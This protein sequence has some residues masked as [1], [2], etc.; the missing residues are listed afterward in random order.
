[1]D[2]LP[3][4]AIKYLDAKSGSKFGAQSDIK[5]MRGLQSKLRQ[6]ARNAR[7]GD[8]ANLNKARIADV[9]ADAITDDIS[10]TEGGE[11]VA[12]LVESAV[13][14]SRELND[15]FRKGAVGTLL[16]FAK[17]GEARV[18][19][20]L[21][22]ENSIGV[23][24]PK[25][26]EAFDDIIKAT[27][28][29]QVKAA[30]DDFIKNKFFDYAVEDG[31]I[32]RSRAESFIRSNKEVLGRLTGVSED[33]TR[34]MTS[35]DVKDLRMAQKGR[36]SFDKPAISRATMFIEK[37]PNKAFNDV[38]GSRNPRREMSNLVNMANRDV[39]GE[40]LDGL[41][42][43]FSDYVKENAMKS[44]FISGGKLD[45][46]LSDPKTRA[47]MKKL[48][49][50]P[51]M[52]RWDVIQHTAKRLDMQRGARASGEG[53]LADEPGKAVSMLAG[54]MG[55]M[56]GHRMNRV[57]G[58]GGN[59]QIPGMAA[60]RARDLLKK[61]LDPAKDLLMA[62]VQDDKLFREVLL[63]KVEP[64]GTLPKEA[65]RR[66]NAWMATLYPEDDE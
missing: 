11:E 5:E 1:M 15:K 55:A 58:A 40:A 42:A 57:L 19:A 12:G 49:S 64:D 36:V 46:Y 59:I 50:A 37:G 48:Y 63:A 23:A 32:N 18:P 33:L 65:T 66:L 45:D 28:S 21:V 54:I 10:M 34:A 4:A 61:G 51:E 8:N 29:P 35:L 31:A 53:V 26:R 47:A 7:S 17:Q 16:G 13:G 2:D 30:M 39:T 62:A 41:K 22:L 25:A 3:A 24:G 6:V 60:D 20:G 14:Y 56:S 38:L 43:A 9:I 52:R 27:E 44:D